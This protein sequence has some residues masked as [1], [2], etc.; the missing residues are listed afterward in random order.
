MGKR[1]P[2]NQLFLAQLGTGCDPKKEGRQIIGVFLY[3][4][5]EAAIHSNDF[6]GAMKEEHIPSWA[7]DDLN[8][9]L[10]EENEEEPEHD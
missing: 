10:E 7:R 5:E 9:I 6:L 8:D 4:R 2:E 1:I 3:D